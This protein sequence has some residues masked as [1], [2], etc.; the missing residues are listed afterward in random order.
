MH[1]GG[2]GGR[3][4]Q[5]LILVEGGRTRDRSIDTSHASAVQL[6]EVPTHSPFVTSTSMVTE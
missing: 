1:N 3:R 2:W 6:G 4:M 5:K